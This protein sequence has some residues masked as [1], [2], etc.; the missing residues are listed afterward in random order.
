MQEVEK[1]G[2]SRGWGG[3]RRG[4]GRKKTSTP[5]KTITV[6]VPFDVAQILDGITVSKSAYVTEAIRHY[7]SS[8]PE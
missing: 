7:A 4:A 1:T 3:A 2:S 5:A 8:R 6:S